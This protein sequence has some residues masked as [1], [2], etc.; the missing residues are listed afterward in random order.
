MR[1]VSVIS[2]SYNIRV[3]PRRILLG[4]GA[5]SHTGLSM[6]RSVR[7]ECRNA[8]EVDP[9]VFSFQST[10]ICPVYQTR[11]LRFALC[12][13]NFHA[14]ALFQAYDEELRTATRTAEKLPCDTQ[15]L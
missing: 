12:V 5:G 2:L 3:E 11:L 1:N 6:G 4:S 8:K 15:R 13:R 9:I 10:M 7:Q 14:A